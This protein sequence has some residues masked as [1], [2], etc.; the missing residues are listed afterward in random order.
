MYL[1]S[2]NQAFPT[3]LMINLKF[4]MFNW[5][6]FVSVDIMRKSQIVLLWLILLLYYK[7][8]EFLY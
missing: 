1:F 2:Y 5:F 3:I 4:F 6:V 7:D 8:I